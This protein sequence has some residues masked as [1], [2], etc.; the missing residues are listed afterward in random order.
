M[1]GEALRA[2]VA[3]LVFA[4]QEGDSAVLSERS[5]D[6]LFMT[7]YVL[8]AVAALHPS[9]RGRSTSSPV[10]VSA[11]GR[12]PNTQNGSTRSAASRV[13]CLVVPPVSAYSSQKPVWSEENSNSSPRHDGCTADSPGPPATVR[14]STSSTSGVGLAEGSAG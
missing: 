4:V 10:A 7:S 2:A 14:V 3:D 1:R 11:I 8:L 5:F 9:M 6:M 12:R 13:S